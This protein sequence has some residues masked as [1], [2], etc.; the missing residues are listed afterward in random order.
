MI[1]IKYQLYAKFLITASLSEVEEEVVS[2]PIPIY[3]G[4]SLVGESL[5]VRSGLCLAGTLDGDA[6]AG[7][8]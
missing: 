5:V 8:I 4:S 3:P 1:L 6:R 2:F 7:Q